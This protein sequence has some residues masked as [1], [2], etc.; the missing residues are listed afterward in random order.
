MERMAGSK[1]QQQLEDLWLRDDCNDTHE[2]D[3]GAKESL[4][5]GGGRH[6]CKPQILWLSLL[7]KK[8]PPQ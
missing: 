1:S 2:D 3:M 8:S 4:G 5:Q 7:I 6:L